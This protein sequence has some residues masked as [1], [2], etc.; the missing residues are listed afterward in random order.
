MLEFFGLLLDPVLDGIVEQPVGGII[1]LNLL[2][3]WTSFELTG[4]IL[5]TVFGLLVSLLVGWM[6]S[7]CPLIKLGL[8]DRTT[9]DGKN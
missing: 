7:P 1:V 3:Y 6:I 9:P 8:S 2:V 4:S 5:P